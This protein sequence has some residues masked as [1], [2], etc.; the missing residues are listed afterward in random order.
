MD[1][2]NGPILELEDQSPPFD[3]EKLIEQYIVTP[4]SQHTTIRVSRTTLESLLVYVPRKGTWDAWLYD[5][6]I[7]VTRPKE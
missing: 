7:A 1:D 6:L 2:P 5:V 4:K 3:P